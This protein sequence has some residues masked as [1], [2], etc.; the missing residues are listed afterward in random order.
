M[1]KTCGSLLLLAIF[2]LAG[3]GTIPESTRTAQ[4][5]PSTKDL[6]VIPTPTYKP[7]TLTSL[8]TPTAFLSAT[9]TID[10]YQ[11]PVPTLSIDEQEKYILNLLA[12]NGNCELPC[13]WGVEPGKT[14]WQDVVRLFLPLGY[15]DGFSSSTAPNTSTHDF[16]LSIN[17]SSGPNLSLSFGVKGEVVEWAY[18]VAEKIHAPLEQ[19][20]YFPAFSV[21]MRRYS[22]NQILAHYGVPSQVLVGLTAGRAEQNAPWLYA[23][24]IFYDHA[25]ILVDYEGEG[26]SNDNGTLTVCPSYDKLFLESF[27]LQ[28]HQSDETLKDMADRTQDINAQLSE[29]W[30]LPI[31]TATGLSLDEFQKMFAS[32]DDKNKE[33][34]FKSSADLWH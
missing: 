30:L 7:P 31:Q 15:G 12:S 34:C 5:S 26:L 33:V 20:S 18:V 11:T 1:R 2:L 3:C 17:Q 21:V 23:L 10:L 8:P 29:G 22:L 6:S 27:Y 19:V 4:V 24:W 28:S 32:K 25:G 13:W 9:P 16:P 14:N